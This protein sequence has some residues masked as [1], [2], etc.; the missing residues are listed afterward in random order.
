MIVLSWILA[1]KLPRNGGRARAHDRPV[2]GDG[3]RAAQPAA[4]AIH[5][6]RRGAAVPLLWRDPAQG[7]QGV[8]S[9]NRANV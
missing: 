2:G 8:L 9:S 3:L 1:S 7:R 6:L 5:A 4:E